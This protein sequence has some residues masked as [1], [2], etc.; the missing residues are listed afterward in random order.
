MVQACG[1]GVRLAWGSPLARRPA[2]ATEAATLQRRLR[3]LPSLE[4]AV[5]GGQALRVALVAVGS[6]PAGG[7]GAGHGRQRGGLA[8]RQPRLPRGD[9]AASTSVCAA[10]AGCAATAS[11]CSHRHRCRPPLRL[12]Q[13]RRCGGRTVGRGL[14]E[15]G[16]EAVAEGSLAHY[17]G[18][19]APAPAVG[20]AAAAPPSPAAAELG[21]P[22][23][24][25]PR[26]PAAASVDPQRLRRVPDG[27][28]EVHHSARPAPGEG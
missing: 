6:K 11:A 16:A 9:A 8:R 22:A 12:P 27:E 17:P 20:A 7:R 3:V 2:A 14:G 4:Q 24:L 28:G 21:V 25:A 26:R 10:K 13:Q 5:L 19:A 18:R 15:G 1:E 23:V